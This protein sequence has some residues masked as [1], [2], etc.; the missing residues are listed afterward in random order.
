MTRGLWPPW[1]EVLEAVC[2]GL[3]VLLGL[4]RAWVALDRRSRAAGRLR[5]GFAR[6]GGDVAL[7]GVFAA[8]V[9]VV[10]AE[11][12]LDA[13]PHEGLIRVDLAIRPLAKDLGEM[14]TVRRLASAVSG[15]TGVVLAG[16]VVGAGF[17]LAVAGRRRDALVLAGG[18]LGAWLLSAGLKLAFAVPRPGTRQT[19]HPISSYGFPSAHALVTV[20]A[21]GLIAWM[22]ARG[23][24]PRE[25]RQLYVGAGTLAGLTAVARVL[26]DVHWLSDVV[27]GL[28]LGL[29]YLSAVLLAVARPGPVAGELA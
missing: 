22:L 5:R 10:A 25:R 27:A 12:I 16:A 19:V 9:F 26:L 20:V 15:A 1:Y 6:Y 18:S 29:V 21:C 8:C 2:V 11:T 13:E 3:V 28:A 23:S 14:P 24:A 4:A 17:G 7:V